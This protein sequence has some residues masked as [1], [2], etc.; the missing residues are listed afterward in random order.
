MSGQSV[1]YRLIV[2]TYLFG[3]LS[4]FGWRC[5][6]WLSN[7]GLF[8]GVCG[9]YC[10]LHCYPLC[11]ASEWISAFEFLKLY[12]CVL[13]Y[14]L[15]NRQVTTTDLDLDLVSLNFDHNAFG[16]EFVNS[17]RL[18]HEHNFEL[19]TIWI[20]VDILS[21]FFINLISFCRD[22]DCNPSFKINDIC[23]ESIYLLLT[24]FK[25]LK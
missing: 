4:C 1:L 7:R 19:L 16:A 23:F 18:A 14:E 15:V 21:Q 8:I 11:E 10:L 13:V 22:V 6:S 24:F 25:S 12:R 2:C 20:V 5:W 17:F 9:C 3:A